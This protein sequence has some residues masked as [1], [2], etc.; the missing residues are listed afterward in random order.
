MSRQAG[1]QRKNAAHVGSPPDAVPNSPRPAANFSGRVSAWPA[2]TAKEAESVL[3]VDVIAQL[4]AEDET[5]CGH[6]VGAR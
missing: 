6:L 2:S 1:C 4:A 5:Q 3:P